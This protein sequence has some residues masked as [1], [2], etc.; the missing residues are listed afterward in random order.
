M[1][2][3]LSCDPK[4]ALKPK[5]LPHEIFDSPYQEILLLISGS[6]VQSLLDTHDPSES[7]SCRI[8]DPVLRAGTRCSEQ[9]RQGRLLCRDQEVRRVHLFHPLSKVATIRRV[10]EPLQ[11]LSVPESLRHQCTRHPTQQDKV[12]TT[13]CW[14]GKAHRLQS[15][16]CRRG[17]VIT[18]RHSESHTRRTHFQNTCIT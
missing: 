1:F 16:L 11:P 18:E 10:H 9:Q 4:R 3:T 17:F 14:K 5:T 12:S 7:V 2:H 13:W 15:P 8:P 6:A